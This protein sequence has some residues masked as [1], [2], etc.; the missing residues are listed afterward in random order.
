M[1]DDEKKQLIENTTKLESLEKRIDKMEDYFETIFK[2]LD[3][4][5]NKI[6]G[7]FST[8]IGAIL[9]SAIIY[10]ITTMSNKGTP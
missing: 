3:S 2:K 8:I 10:I 7:F 1:T 6:I 5:N 4:V 9:L